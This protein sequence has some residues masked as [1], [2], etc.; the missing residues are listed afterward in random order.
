MEETLQIKEKRLDSRL[1]IIEQEKEKIHVKQQDLE[2]I[3]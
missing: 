3:I 1:E 2:K